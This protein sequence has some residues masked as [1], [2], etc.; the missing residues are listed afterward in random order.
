MKMNE[1]WKRLWHEGCIGVTVDGETKIAKYFCKAYDE[2][3]EFGIDDGRISKLSIYID[4][5][6]VVNYD[7]GWD[8]EPADDDQFALIAYAICLESYN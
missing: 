8:I 4:N 7:R 2:G 1:E 6:L 5:A 3:S